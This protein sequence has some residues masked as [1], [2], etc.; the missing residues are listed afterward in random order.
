MAQRL[1]EGEVRQ[2][3][4]AIADDLAAARSRLRALLAR[5][6]R[7]RGFH[8]S[9]RLLEERMTAGR[10][11]AVSLPFRWAGHLEV[12]VAALGEAR[13]ELRQAGA[14]GRRRDG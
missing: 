10:L 6:K 11:P 5:V 1:S 12:A 3:L 2:E 8:R 4:Q 7:T 14:Q 9:R 13:R